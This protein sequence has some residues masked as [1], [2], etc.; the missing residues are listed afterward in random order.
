MLSHENTFICSL[1]SFFVHQVHFLCAFEAVESVFHGL[2]ASHKQS[3]RNLVARAKT[4]QL[5]HQLVLLSKSVE[6]FHHSRYEQNLIFNTFA[7]SS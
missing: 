2:L 6:H 4:L 1:W 3:H 5:H 7:L